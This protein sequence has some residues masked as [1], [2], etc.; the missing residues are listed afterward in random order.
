MTLSTEKE[1][2]GKTLE[3]LVASGFAFS[4]I[5]PREDSSRKEDD[6][7]GYERILRRY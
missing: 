5:D 3:A 4:R 2:Y 7:A 6:L 1:R